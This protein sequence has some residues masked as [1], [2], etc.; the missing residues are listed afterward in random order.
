MTNHVKPS[1][2]SY[3][4]LH[5]DIIDQNLDGLILHGSIQSIPILSVVLDMVTS[6]YMTSESS[7]DYRQMLQCINC[8]VA[9]R[10]LDS[11]LV[12]ER[13]LRTRDHRIVTPAITALGNFYHESSALAIAELLC[14][15]KDESI[16]RVAIP[17][18][19]NILKKCPEVIPAIKSILDSDCVNKRPLRRLLERSS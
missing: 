15:K 6:K 17:S 2:R 10:D 7:E 8:H 13:L 14:S 11:I 16:T 4:I 19:E 12:L 5:Q 1:N 18:L 3:S 9:V